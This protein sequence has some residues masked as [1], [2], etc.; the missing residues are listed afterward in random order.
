[1]KVIKY[2]DNRY[3][4]SV[5]LLNLEQV[6]RVYVSDTKISYESV[7]GVGQGCYTPVLY[8]GT[9]SDVLVVYDLINDF[10]SSSESVLD[11]TIL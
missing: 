5:V 3:G 8:E 2:K 7:L 9:K 10:L 6:V 11:L 1:M 4:K